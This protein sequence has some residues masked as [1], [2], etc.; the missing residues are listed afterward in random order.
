MAVTGPGGTV[1]VAGGSVGDLDQTS[2][3]QSGWTNDDMNVSFQENS[4]PIGQTT[5]PISTQVGVSNITYLNYDSSVF[6]YKTDNFVSSSASR[7]IIVTGRAT[8]WVTGDFIVNGSGYVYI[9]PGASLKLYV[10]GTGS[11][12]GG[13]VVNDSN[14]NGAGLPANFAYYGLTTST[15]LTYSGQGDFVGTIN[16]PQANVKISGGSSVF[17]AVICNTFTSSGG[18][19]VHYDQGLGGGGIFMVTSWTEL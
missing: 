16:A 3:I 19:G 17:G 4:P 10:G 14:G 8:L 12:S 11:I 7:P 13:G 1:S 2:G 15:N 5:A 9:A 6:V 18:S